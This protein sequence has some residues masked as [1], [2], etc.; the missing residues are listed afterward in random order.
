MGGIVSL[1]ATARKSYTIALPRC[2][3]PIP[4]CPQSCITALI[5]NPGL[6]KGRWRCVVLALLSAEQA[7]I[8]LTHGSLVKKFTNFLWLM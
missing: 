2:K 1:A 8:H 3:L 6:G 5:P 7:S 4:V